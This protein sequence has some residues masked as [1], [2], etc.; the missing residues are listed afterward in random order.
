MN[1]MKTEQVRQVRRAALAAGVGAALVGGVLLF[2]PDRGEGSRTPTP[3]ERALAAVSAGAPASLP[4][5]DA[6]IQDR[7][8]WLRTHPEDSTAWAVL[9]AA[10]VERGERRGDTAYY[11]KADEALR[12]SLKGP[13][14][15]AAGPEDHGGRDA[16]AADGDGTDGDGGTEGGDD[17]KQGGLGAPTRTQA[18]A[19]LA[20]LA[21]AR[22]DFTTAKKWGE[23][24]RARQ[25]KAWAAYPVL[26]DAYTGLGDYAAAGRALDKLKEL[27]PGTPA[28]LE[29]AVSV[30]RDRGWREDAEAKA[31]EAVAHAAS[32]TAK[33]EA[34][35]A[36]G[37]LAWERGEPTEAMGHYDAAL[38]TARDHPAALAGRARA[39][40]ALSRTDEAYR[41]YQAALAKLPRPE[42]ALELGELYDAN[43]LD[44]D[45]RTQ[46]ATLRA[47]AARAQGHGVNEELVLAR[48]EADHG[49]PTAA[50]ARLRA[51]WARHHRSMEVA[52]ALGWAL[53]R[54]GHGQEALKYAK[55]ATGQGRRSALFLYH[56]GE[57]ER[58]LEMYGPARRHVGEALR[59]NPYFSPLLAPRALAALESLGE[60]EEGGPRDVE[61]AGTTPQPAE[62]ARPTKPATGA[63]PSG[64][65]APAVPSSP[66][67][68]PVPSSSPPAVS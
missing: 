11:S 42:Y 27:R 48:F 56:R 59:V 35:Y 58:S 10:Y 18:L 29:R 12:R 31:D 44:G 38:A 21:N 57:I 13:P 45:A 53:Y 26:I 33:A 55:K 2:V 50:V 5:L 28:V 22:H 46:Y 1:A 4:D 41:D 20:S 15:G 32:P 7:E 8:K 19:G 16:G 34:L 40:A 54:A 60:P 37:E 36:L 63:T 66:G 61:G 3:Q 17:G 14:V 65:P 43:G 67:P 9:G 68:S 39:L 24:L 47:R 25:P 6:L 51:E 62:V 30:Y 23:T 49:S 52:D 64:S